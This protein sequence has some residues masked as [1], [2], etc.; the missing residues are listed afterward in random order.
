MTLDA[1]VGDPTYN[2]LACVEAAR[3]AQS[4]CHAYVPIAA[5]PA[6]ISYCFAHTQ[7]Q[8]DLGMIIRLEP[9]YDADPPK[10]ASTRTQAR[11]LS[12]RFSLPGCQH[13]LLT[14]ALFSLLH[15]CSTTA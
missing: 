6:T 15:C 2:M 9:V 4:Q 11:V 1:A 8:N 13:L 14:C 5:V 3:G 12:N 7:P 10:C